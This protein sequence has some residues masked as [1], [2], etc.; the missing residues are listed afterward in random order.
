M[1]ILNTFLIFWQTRLFH[2]IAYLWYWHKLIKPLHSLQ[3]LQVS[4]QF[5]ANATIKETKEK[6][7]KILYSI[8]VR[9]WVGRYS[10]KVCS[11]HNIFYLICLF[12][13][14]TENIG[15]KPRKWVLPLAKYPSSRLTIIGCNTGCKFHKSVNKNLK[16]CWFSCNDCASS[17]SGLA[18]PKDMR[19]EILFIK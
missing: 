17:L 14:S 5:K 11:C 10:L 9:E 3:S 16:Y 7:L 2:N 8:W 13:Q 6:N 1:S 4:N 15:P 18:A 19:K 12:S